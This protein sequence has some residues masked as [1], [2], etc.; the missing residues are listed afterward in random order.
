MEPDVVVYA[1]CIWLALSAVAL[2]VQTYR[3]LRFRRQ[4]KAQTA[5]R[6]AQAVDDAPSTS[7][8]PALSS[9]VAIEVTAEQDAETDTTAE[10]TEPAELAEV[11]VAD[12]SATIQQPPAAE[13]Q[14][15]AEEPPGAEEQPAAEAPSGTAA[16]KKHVTLSDLLVG[17]R[18]PCDLHPHDSGQTNQSVR[19]S[20]TG[21]EPAQV[22]TDLADE[23]ERLGFQIAPVAEDSIT[24]S[25]GE[26]LLSLQIR[27][28]ETDVDVDVWIGDGAN[29][30]DQVSVTSP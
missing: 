29:P 15:A 22:G 7:P 5:R 2:V 8:E 12:E 16:P 1:L 25:R 26:D 19:F 21:Y 6:A 10:P 20:T 17:V 4:A 28:G 27:P 23:L 30:F 13:E 18:L 9:E 14:P 3:R 11:P 24:A